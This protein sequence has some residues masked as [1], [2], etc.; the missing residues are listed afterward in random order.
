MLH[1]TINN[2]LDYFRA[3]QNVYC[4]YIKIIQGIKQNKHYAWLMNARNVINVDSVCLRTPNWY[5]YYKVMKFHHFERYIALITYKLCEVWIDTGDGVMIYCLW[6]Y[7]QIGSYACATEE[8]QMKNV[9]KSV[10]EFSYSRLDINNSST[11]IFCWRH[12]TAV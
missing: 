3:C 2:V 12:I 4:L 7:L 8:Q 6:F 10:I 9:R 1:V 11:S 5:P